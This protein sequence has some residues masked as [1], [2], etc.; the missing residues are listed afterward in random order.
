MGAEDKTYFKAI[1][2]LV[3]KDSKYP[4]RTEETPPQRKQAEEPTGIDATNQ[5]SSEDAKQLLLKAKI[6][7]EKSV[8]SPEKLIK[9]HGKRTFNGE[10]KTIQE[11]YDTVVPRN[12]TLSLSRL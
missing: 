4:K 8:N 12:S 11:I 10:E 2:T 9:M 1:G 5:H 3:I 7:R 6:F